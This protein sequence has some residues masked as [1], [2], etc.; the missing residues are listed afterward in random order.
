MLS[1]ETAIGS[2]PV[3][4]V[5]TMERIARLADQLFDYQGWAEEELAELHIRKPDD[6]DE[7]VTG[8]MTMA[9]WRARVRDGEQSAILCLS[10]TSFTARSM[11]GSGRRHRSSASRPTPARSAS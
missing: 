4:A 2:D 9:A 8:A 3:N 5:A 11:A 1:G 6:P 7:A 10:R